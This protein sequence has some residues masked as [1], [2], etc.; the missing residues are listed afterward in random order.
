MVQK[1]KLT[2][3]LCIILGSSFKVAIVKFGERY[4][5]SNGNCEQLMEKYGKD[6]TTAVS[7][8]LPVLKWRGEPSVAII[9]M[10][11]TIFI[12][13]IDQNLDCELDT[14]FDD[15][16]YSHFHTNI[17]IGLAYLKIEDLQNGARIKALVP[18]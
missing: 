2:I 3:S 4:E 11:G 17:W 16:L 8:T 12:N 1:M 15:D 13:C 10:L 18:T 6:S 7:P 14:M 5:I 9:E